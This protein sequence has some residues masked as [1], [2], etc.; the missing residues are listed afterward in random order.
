MCPIISILVKLLLDGF[1]DSSAIAINH[2]ATIAVILIQL[3]STNFLHL[4]WRTHFSR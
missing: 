2:S 3:V 1:S 4:Q